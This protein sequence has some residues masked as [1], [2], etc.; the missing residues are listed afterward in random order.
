MKN[1]YSSLAATEF[2]RRTVPVEKIGEG[3][4][5][6]SAGIDEMISAAEGAYVV[7]KVRVLVLSGASELISLRLTIKGL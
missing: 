7:V 2:G 6:N 5:G 3:K 4:R 1:I